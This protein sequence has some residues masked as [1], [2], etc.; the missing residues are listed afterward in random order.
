M[1][2]KKKTEKPR[3][4]ARGLR[5]IRSKETGDLVDQYGR[6]LVEKAGEL[7][8]T[9]RVYVRTETTVGDYK[10]PSPEKEQA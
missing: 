6:G 9:G 7:V 2:K 5:L 4:K 10:G 3:G 1:T 8:P